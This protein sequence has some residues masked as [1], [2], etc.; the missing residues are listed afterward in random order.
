AN[1]EIQISKDLEKFHHLSLAFSQSFW[2]LSLDGYE[3]DGFGLGFG[4]LMG[5]STGSTTG[6]ELGLAEPELGNSR[7]DKP[8]RV[9][10]MTSSLEELISSLVIPLSICMI[11]SLIPILVV[12]ILIASVLIPIKPWWS[13]IIVRTIAK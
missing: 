7:L 4:A 8:V 6:S 10:N 3:I 12:L 1:I 9:L 11:V 2:S 13:E 5:A